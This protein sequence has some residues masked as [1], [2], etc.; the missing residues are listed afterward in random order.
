MRY[1]LLYACFFMLFAPAV[2][3][4]SSILEGAATAVDGDTLD[5]SGMAVDIDGV[6]APEEKQTCL[7]GS[8]VWQCGAE[9]RAYLQG[10]VAGHLVICQTYLGSEG[11]GLVATCHANDQ[12]IGLALIEAGLVVATDAAAETYR[13][14]EKIRQDNRFGLWASD[15]ETPAQWRSKNPSATPRAK[16]RAGPTKAAQSSRS[17]RTYRNEFGCAI[18]G[19]RS[20]RG[21]WIYHLPGMRYY[22]STRPEEL[23]CT[24]SDA[25][26]AGYRRSKE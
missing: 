4:Q 5:F 23:F 22:D 24:E 1:T 20:I 15:F 6:D 18:K 26:S 16:S 19:N 9:A 2:Y 13:S 17:E 10:L 12:D 7:R 25:V 8:E 21:D 14:A 11:Q 3:A